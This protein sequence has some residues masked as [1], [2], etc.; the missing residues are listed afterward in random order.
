MGCDIRE[1]AIQFMAGVLLTASD[2]QDGQH[3]LANHKRFG[4]WLED[5]NDPVADAQGIISRQRAGLAI[6]CRIKPDASRA[7]EGEDVMPDQMIDR[8]EHGAIYKVA[9]FYEIW[10]ANNRYLGRAL[11]LTAARRAL[12]IVHVAPPAKP[13]G[14]ALNPKHGKRT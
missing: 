9:G 10:G 1:D 7:I 8:N 12:R 13:S 14:H 6:G 2:W 4:P 5:G 11:N 3:A